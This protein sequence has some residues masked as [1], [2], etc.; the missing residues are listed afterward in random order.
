MKNI[1][2]RVDFAGGWL[3]V[4]KFSRADAFIVNCAITPKVSLDNWPY[5][6]G[7]GLGGSAAYAILN[8]KDPIR[9]ELDLGVGWQDPAIINETGLC[10]WRSGEKPILEMKMNPDF[11]KGKMALFW[12]GFS[13]D[14]PNSVDNERDYDLIEKAGLMAFE[15]AKNKSLAVLS[16]AINLSYD[17]QLRE[18]MTELPKFGELAKKYCGGGWGG[19]ALYLFNKRPNILL[20]IEPYLK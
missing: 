15:A 14:T 18:G 6:K 9:S 12:T 11:L 2:L 17:V 13:H 8:D 7:S 4:P 3:D 19:Y 10:V 16:T 5:Q 20:N 1:P